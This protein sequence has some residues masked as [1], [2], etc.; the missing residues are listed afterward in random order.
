MLHLSFR[1]SVQ[2]RLCSPKDVP[3]PAFRSAQHLLARAALGKGRDYLVV[4]AGRKSKHRDR[5]VA[6]MGTQRVR[7]VVVQRGFLR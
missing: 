1:I 6:V 2:T 4:K 3:P 7:T 5:S